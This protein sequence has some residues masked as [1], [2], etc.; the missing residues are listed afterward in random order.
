MSQPRPEGEA[1]KEP[2]KATHDETGH[3]AR[4][5]ESA[6]APARA[7]RPAKEDGPVVRL[8]TRVPG[9]VWYLLGVAGASVLGAGAMALAQRRRAQ[10]AAKVALSDPLTGVGNRLAFEHQLAIDWHRWRRYGGGLGVLMLDLDGFK[11]VND[12]S[13]HAAGDRRLRA[14]AAAI[15]S[16]VRQ[17]DYVA[18]FGGDEFVVISSHSDEP[19]LM[20]LTAR[21]RGG[22]LDAGMRVSIGWAQAEASDNCAEQ[23]LHRADIA[24]YADKAASGERREIGDFSSVVSAGA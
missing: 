6:S 12:E 17:S 16:T 10:R 19:G 14:A 9:W 11:Q 3:R 21:L 22:L 5:D 23:L 18:R 4:T 2:R 1:A 8:I 24:M 7:R 13:G 20:K 15:R